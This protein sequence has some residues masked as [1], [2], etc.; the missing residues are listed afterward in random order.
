MSPFV[1][2]VMRAV[3]GVIFAV[4]V[5]RLFHPE[6]GMVTVMIVAIILVGLAYI[7]E[8]FRKGKNGPEGKV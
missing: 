1:I 3:M 5:M 4:L 6:A 8:S 7:F 2:F